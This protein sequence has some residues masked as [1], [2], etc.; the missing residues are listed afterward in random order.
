MV[1]LRIQYEKV[2]SIRFC[3]H[4][5]IMRGFRRTFAAS[6]IPV[7]FSQGFNPHP[8]LSF[9][10]SLRTGWEGDEEYMDVQLSEPVN[11]F[12]ARCNPSLP[13]GLR[14]KRT[15]EVSDGVPKLTA[16]VSAARYELRIHKSSLA[17]GKN[18]RWDS[19]LRE[20]TSDD[21]PMS[22]LMRSAI[23]Q[24]DV[25][26]VGTSDG[27]HPVS[28]IELDV[29]EQDGEIRIDYLSSMRGGKSI[30]PEDLLE[31]YV[32]DPND[33][34]TPVRTKRK[35]L[36]VKRGGDLCSPINKGVVQTAL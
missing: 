22:E 27:G 28:L 18:S 31:P 4:R 36:Y 16:D 19:F 17:A 15:V 13:G 11:D 3:S 33:L 12:G 5:D 23:E 35:A 34:E 14:I 26:Q 2:D 25:W 30:F 10:P 7:C 9:G 20:S 24:L 8:R 29:Y 21:A 1:R 32:G 6:Q